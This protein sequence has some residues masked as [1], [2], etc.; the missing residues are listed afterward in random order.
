MFRRARQLLHVYA[1][2]LAQVFVS[3][4]PTVQHHAAFRYPM[5]HKLTSTHLH[6]LTHTL[7]FPVCLFTNS[8]RQTVVGKYSYGLVLLP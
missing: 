3:V 8:I 5:L 6:I 1:V 7:Q 4:T 2:P